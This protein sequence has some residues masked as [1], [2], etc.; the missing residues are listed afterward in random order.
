V[1]DVGFDVVD[2]G[3][4]GDGLLRNHARIIHGERLEQGHMAKSG[5][6]DTRSLE[7]EA[8]GGHIKDEDTDV[9]GSSFLANLAIGKIRGNERRVCPVEQ[10]VG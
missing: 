8:P 6:D 1:G 2:V 4:R 5:T 7:S 9:A 10:G 3:K